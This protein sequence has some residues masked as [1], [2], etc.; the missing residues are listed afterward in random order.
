VS[1]AGAACG[2][3]LRRLHGDQAG[4]TTVEWV[5]LMAGFGIPMVWVFAQLLSL[6]AE[7]YNMVT[8]LETLPFP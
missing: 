8:F 6:L 1:A 4:Q 5:L 7:H 3:G 2:G